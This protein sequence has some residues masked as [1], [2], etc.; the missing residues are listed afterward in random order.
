MCI[1]IYIHVALFFCLCFTSLFDCVCVCACVRKG[2][3]GRTSSWVGAGVVVIGLCMD[4]CGVSGL[5]GL[6]SRDWWFDAL[7][8]TTVPDEPPQQLI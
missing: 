2:W 8:A 1:Y 4:S 5:A 6:F 7:V 3:S